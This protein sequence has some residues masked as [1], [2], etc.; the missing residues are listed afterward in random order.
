MKKFICQVGIFIS[1]TVTVILIMVT[2][3]IAIM[4]QASFKIDSNKNILILGESLTE[5]GIDDNIFK[6]GINL[7]QS[8]SAYIYSYCKLKKILENN[9]H[10]DTVILSFR[11]SSL[12]Q[13]SEDKWIM[14]EDFLVPKVTFHITLLEKEDFFIYKDKRVLLQA[15][16]KVPVRNIGLIIKYFRKGT[17]IS[18]KDMRIGGYLK[19]VR[20]QLQRDLEE[21]WSLEETDSVK[22]E[23]SIQ[24]KY[25]LKIVDYCKENNVKLILLNMPIYK[26][27]LYGSS[28]KLYEYHSKYLNGIDLLDYSNFSLPDE[29]YYGDVAHLNYKGA[30]IFSRYLQLNLSNDL[31]MQN[32]KE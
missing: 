20:Q 29:S 7:S 10:I 5:T 8:G 3:T 14:G 15:I 26:P 19:L 17:A 6:R 1:I 30:E 22:K 4:S 21:N 16:L 2:I 27:E 23:S 31:K 28:D 18:Y 24:K 9:Q 12:L 25:L 13:E 32:K 11:Y